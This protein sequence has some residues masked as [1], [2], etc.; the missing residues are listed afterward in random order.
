M[1]TTDLVFAFPAILLAMVVTAVARPGPPERRARA[2]DRRLAGVRARRARARAHVGDSEYVQSARLLGAI[3]APDARARRAAEL[4]RPGDRAR[5]ARGRGSDAAALGPL[6]PRARRPA[7]HAEW[8]A[9]V[10]EGTQYFQYWWMGTFPGL[11]IF[12]VVLAFNFVGDSLR[13]IFDP[14]SGRP[15]APDGRELL[16][17]EGMRV[18]SHRR[19]AD[20]DRRRRRLSRSSRARSSASPG[21]S[22]SG[23]T[24]TM[25]AL[26]GAAAA[27][28]R[29]STG[30]RAS[31]AATCSTSPAARCAS[32][33]GASSRWSSRTR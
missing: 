18:G 1:R 33:P 4:H 12:T 17:V 28:G 6:V 25:L 29:A 24:M 21:E 13:D 10:A 9:M 3:V 32:S 23:K 2:R 30:A 15:R 27:R 26:L 16:E 5:D 11:A 31:T 8:G 19:R 7:A 14:R 20:H 22:G